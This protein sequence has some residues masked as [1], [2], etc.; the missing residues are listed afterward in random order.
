MQIF[1]HESPRPDSSAASWSTPVVGVHDVPLK[2]A[3]ASHND[4]KKVNFKMKEAISAQF[5]GPTGATREQNTRG[6]GRGRGT[7]RERGSTSP[8]W[9]D[10]YLPN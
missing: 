4:E 3:P 9:G 6:R 5:H 8:H 7:G 1:K 2:R 10:P